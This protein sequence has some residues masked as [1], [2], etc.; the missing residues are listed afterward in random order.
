VISPNVTNCFIL[1]NVFLGVGILQ[2]CVGCILWEEQCCNSYLAPS[3]QTAGY[4]LST[5]RLAK[6][7]IKIQNKNEFNDFSSM[8]RCTHLLLIKGM[9]RNQP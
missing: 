4:F 5:P 8:E 1:A 6:L 9:E 3:S 7:T 2:G